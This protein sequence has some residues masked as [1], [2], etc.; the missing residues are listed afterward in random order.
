MS[1][2]NG[3]PLPRR[4]LPRRFKPKWSWVQHRHRP[5]AGERRT[6]I[7]QGDI[8][9]SATFARRR[10]QQPIKPKTTCPTVLLVL[11][12]FG[13]HPMTDLIDRERCGQRQWES[14]RSLPKWKSPRRGDRVGGT[15]DGSWCSSG[16][17]PMDSATENE[18]FATCRRAASSY[19]I[20]WGAVT[21]S[22][23]DTAFVCLPPNRPSV[24]CHDE[25]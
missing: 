23:P 18:E 16:E 8:R 2:T 3:A 5:H 22:L 10:A 17:Q 14:G 15:V 25:W 7:L 6:I 1:S 21:T 13:F 12:P 20:L 4:V 24:A 19:C 9:F 11:L